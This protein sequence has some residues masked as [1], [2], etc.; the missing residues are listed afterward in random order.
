MVA[1]LDE[2]IHHRIGTLDFFFI[3]MEEKDL[4]QLTT[5]SFVQGC[6]RVHGE[7]LEPL[8]I[9]SQYTLP[10][11]FVFGSKYKGKTNERLSQLLLN[12]GL[13]ALGQDAN[14]KLK[15]LDPMCGRGTTLWWAARYGINA[16]GIEQDAKAIEELRRHLKKWTKLHRIKH[17]LK[18]G[19]IGAA[20]KKNVGKFIDITLPESTLKVTI[21]DS[22]DAP[23][24]LKGETFD[25]LIADLP[26]GVQ[27]FTTSKTRNPLA[28]VQEALPGWGQCL[29]KNGAIVLAFNSNLPK[30][31]ALLATFVDAGFKALDFSA[32]H[33]MSESILRDVVVLQKG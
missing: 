21:G 10:D 29:K 8:D 12:V 33:R 23:E 15:I 18:E 25:L 26:Y 19:S 9:S 30:R 16:K 11:D 24:L 17:Q 31:K 7:K 4:P 2:P 14:K 5:L 1:G 27:H 22:R 13:A 32:P 28:V 3:D 6:Y 20:K